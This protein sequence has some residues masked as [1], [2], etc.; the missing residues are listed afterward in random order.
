VKIKTKV[1]VTVMVV[2]Q[3]DVELDEESGD[4]D[5]ENVAVNAVSMLADTHALR[6]MDS[7]A[8]KIFQYMVGAAVLPHA[9]DRIRQSIVGYTPTI[10]VDL[11]T[12][13]AKA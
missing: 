3:A 1:I 8:V 10:Q 6:P 13:D 12:P 7:N 9:I 5:L 4:V 2:G 11:N